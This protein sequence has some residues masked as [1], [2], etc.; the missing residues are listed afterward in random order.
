[1]FQAVR[2]PRLGLEARRF[3]RVAVDGTPSE[4]A[5]VYP[6]Q[7]VAD[8]PQ[9]DGIRICY[10]ERFVLAF[11]GDAGVGFVARLLRYLRERVA[12]FTRDAIDQRRFEIEQATLEVLYVHSPGPPLRH[13]IQDSW[14]WRVLSFARKIPRRSQRATKQIPS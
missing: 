12:V 13:T 3:D 8:L 2:R 7:S 5:L 14:N 4:C 1:M 10:C 9:L 6:A 11:V